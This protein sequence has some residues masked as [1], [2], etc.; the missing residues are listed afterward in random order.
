[1]NAAPLQRPDLER[2]L[3]EAQE[4]LRGALSEAAHPAN[5][6][7][8]PWEIPPLELYE[9]EPQAQRSLEA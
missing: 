5:E 4:A 3:R 2:E 9:D 1:V 6:H 8:R 7:E